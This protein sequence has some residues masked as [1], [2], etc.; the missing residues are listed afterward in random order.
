MIDYMDINPNRKVTNKSS[1]NTS[2]AGSITV[3]LKNKRVEITDAAIHKAAEEFSELAELLGETSNPDE[4][5]KEIFK[6]FK[7]AFKEFN[8]RKKKKKGNQ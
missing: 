6:H 8:R 4:M 1:Q 2:K 7:E 3:S 5:E